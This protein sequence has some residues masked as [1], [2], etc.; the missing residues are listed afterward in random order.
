MRRAAAAALSAVVTRRPAVERLRQNRQPRRD[1]RDA[2]LVGGLLDQ[3][4]VAA[5]LRRRLE[6]AVRLVRNAFIRAEDTDEAIELVVV[7]LD[8]VV[9]DRPVV[10]EAIHAAALEV[11]RP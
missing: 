6:D 10:A 5:R 2:Q 7:R 8:V 4:L 3:Q 1:A 11:V 9:R